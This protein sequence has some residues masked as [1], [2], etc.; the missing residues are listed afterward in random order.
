MIESDARRA[1]GV[2][3]SSRRPAR[4]RRSRGRCCRLRASR[5][6]SARR[7]TR[8]CEDAESGRRRNPASRRSGV[9]CAAK[10][11]LREIL[12]AQ[13]PWS[14][15]PVLVLTRPGADS[16]GARRSGP[17]ARQ[18]DAAGA[19]G[20]RGDA[21]QCGPHRRFVRA[22]ASIRSAGTSRSGRAPR[23]SL[24]IADQRKDEFLATLGHELRNPLAPLLTGLQLLKLAGLKDPVAAQVT[25][26]SWSARSATSSGWWTI[27]SKCRASRA[28]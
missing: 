1:T 7:S 13:P 2:Y 10:R 18:R 25:A 11:R 19:P 21:A 28:G 23:K 24:R 15:L 22:S 9:V 14:D 5:S 6:R 16:A 17:D 20:A 26:R 3:W 12:A 8:W 27:C 4:T